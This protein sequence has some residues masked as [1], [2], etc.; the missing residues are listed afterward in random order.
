[1]DITHSEGCGNTTIASITYPEALKN[2]ISWSI[3][4]SNI[5]VKKRAVGGATTSTS[6]TH[7]TE[8]PKAD[9]HILMFGHNDSYYGEGDLIETFVGNYI[10]L[11]KRIINWDSAVILLVPP[12]MKDYNMD[13]D[14]FR[15]IVYRIADL[16]NCP[17]YDT[18]EFLT[19][20]PN[21][22]IHIT[23][24]NEI[25]DGVHFNGIG[26]KII[27]YNLVNK[28]LCDG[29]INVKNKDNILADTY[30]G[31]I[32]E[33]KC[34]RLTNQSKILGVGDSSDNGVCLNI[35][36]TGNIL[37]NINSMEEDLCLIPIFYSESNC[38]LRISN[39]F[40]ST[41]KRYSNT[42]KYKDI[43]FLNTITF[44][45]NSQFNISGY[46]KSDI[47][48]K[49]IR[50]YKGNN[51]I[52]VDNLTSQ[53]VDEGRCNFHGFCVVSID[54]IENDTISISK[55]ISESGVEFKCSNFNNNNTFVNAVIFNINELSYNKPIAKIDGVEYL[56]K[57]VVVPCVVRDNEWRTIS[58]LVR[59]NKENGEIIYAINND[60][61]S[62]TSPFAI[63]INS[64]I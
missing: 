37:F 15:H 40:N 58:G 6:F 26:Y 31:Y 8:N 59:F 5:E 57:S 13:L 49:L 30:N 10:K 3:N 42:D 2:G 55:L 12:S 9:L 36:N 16:F 18:N 34:L 1:M 56:D 19:G 46:K 25:V 29:V 7:F 22:E 43:E 64:I 44:T 32:I 39:N 60:I 23:V 17:V 48:N 33:D 63:Y 54:D 50:L 20:Y 52:K 35:Q 51:V 53:G 47:N 41:D 11:I 45:G 62:L 21:K 28:I 27:G 4:S 38:V 24:D 61:G 14:I